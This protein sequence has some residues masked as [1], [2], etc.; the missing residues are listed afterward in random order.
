MRGTEQP[1]FA[2]AILDSAIE[3]VVG[4]AAQ[5]R[6]IERLTR[7]IVQGDDE[8]ALRV[9]LDLPDDEGRILHLEGSALVSQTESAE[10]KDHLRRNTDLALGRGVFG[11]PTIFVGERSFWGNDRLHFVEAELKRLR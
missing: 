5:R 2:L 4:A 6:R 11:V 1:R 8:P 7:A 3:G 9:A 10:I